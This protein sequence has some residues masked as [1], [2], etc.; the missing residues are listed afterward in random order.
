MSKFL[1]DEW[2]KK[3]GFI[4]D[5]MLKQEQEQKNQWGGA[6]IK[7]LG[8]AQPI[9]I[10]DKTTCKDAIQIMKE[11][12]FDQLPVTKVSDSSKLLGV[13]TLGNILAKVASHRAS[14]NDSVLTCAFTF[15][16]KKK[17][18]EITLETPLES[19]SKF[20]EK[21]SSAV[22]T[23]RMGDEFKVL[24]VVTKVDLLEYLVHKL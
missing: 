19:L 15:D 6:C 5:K 9:S 14:L 24:H 12:G 7:D 2:M 13:V 4:D 22:V 11:K 21:N 10:S 3:Y 8:L 17:F 1:N 23:E 20:F 16:P 18:V